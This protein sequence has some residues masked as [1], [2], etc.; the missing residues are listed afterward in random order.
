[1]NNE[2]ERQILADMGQIENMLLEDNDGDR[3]R[4]IIIH[5]DTVSGP[6]K[7]Q[8]EAGLPDNERR[9]TAQVVEGLH[10]AQRILT[11]VWETTHGVRLPA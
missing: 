7:D 2:L 8:L 11:Q 5:L 9:A 4:A 6:S 1:M 3:T 10:A